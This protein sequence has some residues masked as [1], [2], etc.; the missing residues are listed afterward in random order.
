M[1]RCFLSLFCPDIASGR[2]V[3]LVEW[4]DRY[5]PLVA[6][7][8][9]DGIILDITGCAH[10]FGGEGELLLDIKRRLHR[11]GVEAHA[12]IADTWGA[13]WA[14]ARYGNK[15]IVHG[16]NTVAA[17]DPLPVEAL[18][19]PSE[20]VFELRRLGLID[21]AAVR[22]IPRSSLTARFG[23]TLLWRLD[24][25][26]HKVEDPLTPWRPPAVYR[27]SC[28]LAEPISTTGSVEYVLRNLLREVCAKLEKDH[29]GSRRMDLACYRVD[30]TVDRCEIRTSKPN[31]TVSHLLRLFSG[32]LETLWAAFGFET[33]TLSVLS[34]EALKAEQ[35]SLTETN[36]V[37]DEESFDALIDR[38][39]MKLGFQE[40]NRV[41][42][43]ESLLPEHSVEFR[44]VSD[45]I[46]PGS[47]WPTYRIR[48]IRLIDPPMR[49]E[50]SILIPGGSPVQFLVGRRQHR[51]VRSEGP[52]RLA[53]EWWRD[54]K[55]RW[56]VRDY[57][58]IED[59]QGLRFWIF[60]HAGDWFLHGHLP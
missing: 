37:G 52:E 54:H 39:G 32:R 31:R 1:A 23:S 21:I 45:P 26:F 28:I 29:L 42:I 50:V 11:M 44:P 38:L 12:A 48:P 14:L 3:R 9:C 8:G 22:K 17:L 13:A 5:S 43:C 19:L 35:L 27:A 24:Q 47:K 53:P 7:D 18:R 33:F 4:C 20:I 41:R 57:Y 36:P 2:L 60:H 34:S 49:I 10:L 25:A 15:F 56:G 40:V 6:Q 59:E 58:R 16:E 51:I 30:G 46:A 55:S